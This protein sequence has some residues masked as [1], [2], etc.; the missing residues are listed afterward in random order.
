M[1][2]RVRHEAHKAE[3][4]VNIKTLPLRKAVPTS[5]LEQI[6]IKRLAVERIYEAKGINIIMMGQI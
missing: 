5:Q 4:I 1:H 6:K 2:T 3:G